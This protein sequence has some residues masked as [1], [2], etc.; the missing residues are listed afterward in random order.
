MIRPRL[1]PRLSRMATSFWRAVARAIRRLATL[2]QAM[3]STR[4]TMAISTTSGAD[5]CSRRLDMPVAAGFSSSFLARNRALFLSLHFSR[6]LMSSF[7]AW[8]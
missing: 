6:V 4:P 3:S 1:A 8:L 5:T 2:A 7:S